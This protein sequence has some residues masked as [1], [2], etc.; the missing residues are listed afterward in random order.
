MRDLVAEWNGEP[1]LLET[2]KRLFGDAV[3]DRLWKAFGGTKL[4]LPV[5]PRVDHPLVLAVGADKARAICAE[6][7]DVQLFVPMAPDASWRRRRERVLSLTLA[8]LP[9]RLIAK[10][11]DCTER[12]VA[13]LRADLRANG[14]LPPLPRKDC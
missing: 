11:A 10:L 14:E 2:A 6:I 5:A 13:Q 9:V 8:G 1:C 3:R 7:G 12:R 4:H